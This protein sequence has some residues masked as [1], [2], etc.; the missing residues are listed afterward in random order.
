M[1]ST[2]DP[3]ASVSAEVLH[4]KDR[5]A[6]AAWRQA[7][8]GVEGPTRLVREKPASAG[9]LEIVTVECSAEIK[10]GLAA[11]AA[12]HGIGFEI[13]VQAAWGIL[14]GCLTGASDVV[15]GVT[16]RSG[17]GRDGAEHHTVQGQAASRRAALWFAGQAASPAICVNAALPSA[18]KRYGAI[19]RLQRP[20]RYESRV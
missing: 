4:E 5:A 16:V 18:V 7:L 14:L 15:F 8:A 17:T 10:E 13:V 12:Q 9:N 19:R 3:Q 20:V 6:A 2:V 1:A 11:L